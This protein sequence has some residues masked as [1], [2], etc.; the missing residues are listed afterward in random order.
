M[1]RKHCS[2]SGAEFRLANQSGTTAK[3]LYQLTTRTQQSLRSR[4]GP[5]CAQARSHRA[6]PQLPPKL[7][8]VSAPAT[9]ASPS[10]DGFL[11]ACIDQGSIRSHDWANTMTQK[12]HTQDSSTRAASASCSAIFASCC[13]ASDSSSASCDGT[14]NKPAAT[15]SGQERLR[16]I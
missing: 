2:N 1:G 13:C 15:A 14:R 5:L 7:P 8:L 4:I 10:L 16:R 12:A 3:H 9:P 6:S 11:P